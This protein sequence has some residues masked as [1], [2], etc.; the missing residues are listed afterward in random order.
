MLERP[1]WEAEIPLD[2]LAN[3]QIPV[4]LIRGDWCP[5][6]DTARA[7]AGAAFHAVCDELE[8]QLGARRVVLP[9]AHN[10]QKLGQPFNG[11]LR[12]FWAET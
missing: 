8:E 2:A 4:L 1:P 6:P 7:R 11:R 3:A 9:A 5:A 10:P 12:S